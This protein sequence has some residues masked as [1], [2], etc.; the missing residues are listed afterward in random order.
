[1]IFNITTIKEKIQEKNH[2]EIIN[3]RF[4]GV[5]LWQTEDFEQRE[6]CRYIFL[7]TLQL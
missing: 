2:K 4:G 3:F 7:A 6:P 5:T 1:M